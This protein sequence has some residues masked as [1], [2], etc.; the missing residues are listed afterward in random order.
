MSAP[1]SDVCWV[2]PLG[3]MLP[4]PDVAPSGGTAVGVTRIGSIHRALAGGLTVDTFARKRSWVWSWDMLLEEQLP[5]LEAL[6]YGT[7]PGPL[8]LIDPRRFNRLPEDIASG[9]SVSGSNT[10]FGT[11]AGSACYWHPLTD[12]TTADISTLPPA[13]MLRGFQEWQVLAPVADPATNY[14]RIRNPHDTV[15]SRW[16]VPV[17]PG[18]TIRLST[19]VLGPTDS[20]VFLGVGWYNAAGVRF[21]FDDLTAWV[22][23]ALNEWAEL[24]ATIAVPAGAVACYMVLETNADHMAPGESVYLTALQIAAGSLLDLVPAGLTK[25]C[26]VPEPAGG[27]RI[28]GGAP[29]VVADVG[30][31]TYTRPGFYGSGLTLYET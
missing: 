28:G 29:Y 27:W 19:W 25:H 7:I 12:A 8:R 20:E 5:F 15:D 24:A 18:E 16:K 10:M 30:E 14:V 11:D 31:N 22:P 23:L 6:Q 2:G 4:L 3:R 9:G 26:D 1:F 17:L 21:Q 13:P